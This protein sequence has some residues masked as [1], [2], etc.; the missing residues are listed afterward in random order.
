M[1]FE[2]FTTYTEVDI[3]D[4][5]TVTDLK[6]DGSPYYSYDSYIYKDY[7]VGHFTDYIHDLEVMITNSNYL[8]NCFH[9]FWSIGNEYGARTDLT[10]GQCLYMDKSSTAHLH[11]QDIGAVTLDTSVNLSFS[12]NYFLRIIRSDTSLICKIY[13]TDLDRTNDTNAVDTLSVVCESTAWRYLQ[14][15]FSYKGAISNYSIPGYTQNLDIHDVPTVDESDTINL[16]DN[17]ELNLSLEKEELSDSLILSDKISFGFEE[18]IGGDTITL[19]DDIEIINILS[20]DLEDSLSLSDNIELNIPALNKKLYDT[21]T[22]SDVLSSS[23]FTVSRSH[24]NNYFSMFKQITEDLENDV[25][26]LGLNIED[27]KNDVRFLQSWQK[28]GD[29]GFQSLGKEYVKVY[30]DSVEEINVDI[31]TLSIV[32]NLGTAHTAS[33]ILG[34]AYDSTSKPTVDSEIEIKYNIWTLFKGYIVSLAPGDSPDNVLVNCRDEYWKQNRTNK[35]FRVGHQP[36]DNT[37]L[38]Y[39]TIAGALSSE[40]S[41]SPGIGNFVPENIDCFGMGSS[42]CI[43]SLITQCGNYDWFY[44]VNKNS[45]TI[46]K[47]LQIDGSG[48]I[49]NIERQSIGKNIKLY[50]LIKHQIYESIE[51]IVNKFRVQM[52]NFTTRIFNSTGGKKEW[53]SWEY[54]THLITLTPGWSPLYEN[55]GVLSHSVESNANYKDVFIKYNIPIPK[56]IWEEWSDTFPPQLYITVP[57]GGLWKLSTGAQELLNSGFTVDYGNASIF[58]NQRVYMYQADEDTGELT[59]IRAP[60]VQVFIAKKKYYSSTDSPSTNP[61]TTISNPLMFFTDKMGSYSDTI[62]KNL[63]L[64]QFSIQSGGWYQSGVTD[65][66][67]VIYS[68]IPSWNDTVFAK[69]FANWQLSK[70][71]DKKIN[72]TIELTIDTICFYDI[73][74]SNRIMINGVLENALNIK[75]IN[76]SFGSWMATITLQNGR[77]YQRTASLPSHGL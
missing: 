20:K 13:T 25:R 44:H 59:D 77:E 65:E 38:Y 12:V 30:I 37:E 36:Q 35:Y 16:N 11:L 2:N 51:N 58:F 53:S 47:K 75:T 73:D 8:H 24:L 57:F 32:Q 7:G 10:V 76:Y 54:K 46:S 71:C 5:W 1:A 3:E 29:A 15:G 41:W 61:E 14:C 45:G 39:N 48:D 60:L 70:N 33:F 6:C 62:M 18:F 55:M 23:L 72:G 49:I 50:Q 66:G 56:A 64:S 26:T 19:S 34:L 74:L 63:E 42:D 67:H 27:L 4:R 28:P 9:G 31:D 43:T 40:L 22:L 17:I 52:G 68:Y 69:D 21:L